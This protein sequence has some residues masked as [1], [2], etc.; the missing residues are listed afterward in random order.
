[1]PGHCK[2]PEK[3]MVW[4]IIDPMGDLTFLFVCL[5]V[6]LACFQTFL[7]IFIFIHVLCQY[8]SQP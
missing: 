6:K 7:Y 5:F 2:P 8:C 4:K 1:M 3:P